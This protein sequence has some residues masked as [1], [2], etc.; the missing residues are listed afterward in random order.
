MILSNQCTRYKNFIH[1]CTVT[2]ESYELYEDKF[3]LDFLS[4]YVWC[5]GYVLNWIKK[6]P[7]LKTKKIAHASISNPKPPSA[8][9]SKSLHSIM[10]LT[11]SMLVRAEGVYSPWYFLGSDCLNVANHANGVCVK[12]QGL[13]TVFIWTHGVFL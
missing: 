13:G 8:I 6:A 2:K 1:I 5:L 7:N 3:C 10:D 12:F 11:L 9:L 4:S